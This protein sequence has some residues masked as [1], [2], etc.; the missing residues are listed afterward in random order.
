MKFNADI[1]INLTLI[2][3]AISVLPMCLGYI[4]LNFDNERHSM[5]NPIK[6]F[7]VFTQHLSH[8]DSA[9]LILEGEFKVHN[10]YWKDTL[11]CSFKVNYPSETD[12]VIAVIQSL[13]MRKNESTGQC[14]DFIQFSSKDGSSTDKFCGNFDVSKMNGESS[15]LDV[16]NYENS[17]RTKKHKLYTHINI[18]KEPFK[19]N[20]H[21]EFKVIY[22][23]YRNCSQRNLMDL[24]YRPCKESSEFCIYNG[25]FNDNYVNCPLKGCVDEGSCLKFVTVEKPPSIGTKLL[26]SSISFLFVLFVTFLISIWACKKHKV[27]CFSEQFSHPDRNR[28]T[29][30]IEMNEQRSNRL[31]E[32]QHSP[33]APP[34]EVDKD[35]PPKYEDLFPDR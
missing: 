21:L 12:G 35:L 28:E 25:F 30:V 33:N 6:L 24:A 14:I 15:V 4:K 27:I 20:Q 19:R 5:C 23:A 32:T 8:H 1:T 9:G 22:T 29:R 26:V 34:I 16:F 18:G 2:L 10:N 11:H 17:F 13:N 3:L 31:S 7:G